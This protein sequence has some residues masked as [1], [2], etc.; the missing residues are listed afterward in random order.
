MTKTKKSTKSKKKPGVKMIRTKK[1]RAETNG[2]AQATNLPGVK[3]ATKRFT[4]VI[5]L[6]LHTRIKTYC[7]LHNLDMT[8]DVT[9]L[10][11]EKYPQLEE[12]LGQ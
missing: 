10:F 5:P 4:V 7:T 2:L 8:E 6:N 1:S 12:M 3:P 9:K 11:D